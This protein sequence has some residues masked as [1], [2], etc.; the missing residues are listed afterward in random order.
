MNFEN[1]STLR[2]CYDN[3]QPQMPERKNWK[4]KENKGTKVEKKC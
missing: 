1:P 4:I 2:K 3:L